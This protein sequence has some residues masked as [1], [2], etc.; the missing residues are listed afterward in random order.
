[1]ARDMKQIGLVGLGNAG[2]PLGERLLKKGFPLKV[3]DLNPEAA[4][5][6]VKLGAKLA[7]SAEEATCDLIIE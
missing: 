6:L 4:E 2:R 5:P 3:Y 1:M 7:G